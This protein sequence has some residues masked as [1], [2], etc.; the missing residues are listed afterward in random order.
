M[1]VVKQGP[2][3][4]VRGRLARIKNGLRLVITVSVFS[5]AISAELGVNDV[6]PVHDLFSAVQ[7]GLNN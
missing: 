3:A 1:V 7:S 5:Q 4:G 6:E 2:L